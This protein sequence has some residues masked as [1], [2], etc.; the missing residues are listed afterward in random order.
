[1]GLPGA[2]L[3]CVVVVP[4]N[5]DS[6]A[7]RNRLVEQVLRPQGAGETNFSRSGCACFVGGRKV[8]P[9]FYLLWGHYVWALGIA[10]ITLDEWLKVEV[11][12][13]VLQ[14]GLKGRG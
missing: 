1:M 13:S 3:V 11:R 2:D 7:W 10:W 8:L 5:F 9:Q 14:Y 6:V 12:E 4:T